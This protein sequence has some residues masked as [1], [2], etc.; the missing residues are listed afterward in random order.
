MARIRDDVAGVFHTPKGVLRAGDEVPAGV[1][2]DARWLVQVP[3]A[4][5]REA[6]H[7][8][9]STAEWQAF[10]TSQGVEFPEDAKRDD[11]KDIWAEH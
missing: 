3:R 1:R 5:R 8:N 9:A 2:F 11:L 10:L 4:E 7:G 6:P